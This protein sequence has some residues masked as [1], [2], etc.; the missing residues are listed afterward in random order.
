M[1]GPKPVV[2]VRCTPELHQA[3][4]HLAHQREMSMNELICQMLTSECRKA[5]LLSEEP[6]GTA[7][8]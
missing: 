8:D 6:G 7:K 2:T 5:D 3:L 1:E 4:K